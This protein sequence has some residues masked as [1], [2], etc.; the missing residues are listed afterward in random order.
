MRLL[1]LNPQLIAPDELA[2]LF[3]D[4]AT[5]QAMLDV[6]AALAQAEAD[7]GVIPAVAVAAIV[8][9]CDAGPV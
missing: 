1:G 5:V 7:C 2:A 6:E 4:R 3:D 8:A 9:A